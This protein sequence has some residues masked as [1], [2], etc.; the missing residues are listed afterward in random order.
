M[1]LKI[2]I[3]PIKRSVLKIYYYRYQDS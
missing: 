2:N 1:S 3:R